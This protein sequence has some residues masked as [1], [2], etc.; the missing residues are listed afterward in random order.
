VQ[1]LQEMQKFR[2]GRELL[3]S[4][5]SAICA[6]GF[7]IKGE[8]WVDVPASGWPPRTEYR[9]GDLPQQPGPTQKLD[10]RQ[11]L[12]GVQF[13]AQRVTAKVFQ[14]YLAEAA[15]FDP[16]QHRSGIGVPVG[17]PDNP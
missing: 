10:Q 15:Y 6:L 8:L 17:L 7:M 13:V 14:A 1:K 12:L 5:F 11:R 2:S 3:I 9:A 16:A 4:A